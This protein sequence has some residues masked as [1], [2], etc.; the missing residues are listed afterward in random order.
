MCESSKA[1]RALSRMETGEESTNGVSRGPGKKD[2]NSFVASPWAARTAA[3]LKP[4]QDLTASK[5]QKIYKTGLPYL[6]NPDELTMDGGAGDESMVGQ[7][8]RSA[9]VVSDDSEPEVEG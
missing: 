6:Q 8:P 1:E 7:D 9:I 3:Y 5:W 4:I 2:A